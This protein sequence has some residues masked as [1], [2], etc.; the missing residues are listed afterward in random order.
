MF[1]T[2]SCGERIQVIVVK[3]DPVSVMKNF[4]INLSRAMYVRSGDR[5]GVSVYE[6]AFMEGMRDRQIR[7][8]HNSYKMSYVHKVMAKF[9]TCLLYT[10]PSPRDS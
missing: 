1:N 4:P 2:V 8:L 9:P 5:A 7:A 3:Q 6:D 10:S